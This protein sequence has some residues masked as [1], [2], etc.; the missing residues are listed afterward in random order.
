MRR[1]TPSNGLQSGRGLAIAG[2]ALGWIGVGFVV[3]IIVL[4]RVS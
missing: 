2:I 4:P 1:S 3:L